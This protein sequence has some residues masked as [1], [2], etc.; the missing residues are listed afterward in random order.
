LKSTSFLSLA[1]PHILAWFHVKPKIISCLCQTL[2]HPF[3]P[4]HFNSLPIANRFQGGRE[5]VEDRNSHKLPES[6]CPERTR[7][8]EGMSASSEAKL[9]LELLL[10]WCFTSTHPQLAIQHAIQAKQLVLIMS[11]CTGHAC[12]ISYHVSSQQ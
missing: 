11:L 4:R 9:K 1:H 10:K 8:A 12:H 6:W 7:R 3:L 2:L 5:K